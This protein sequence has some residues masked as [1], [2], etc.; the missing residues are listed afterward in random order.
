MG[1]AQL[2]GVSFFKTFSAEQRKRLYSFGLIQEI[3]RAAHAVIEGE[4]SRGLF[5]VFA[6]QL[7]VFKR[8]ELSSES[9]RLTHLKT[10]DCFGE[11]SL[12]DLAPR[13]ATVSADMISFIYFLDAG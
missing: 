9:M 6:G 4:P 11:L 10:R 13:S 5:I 8:D 12:I 3:K 7:S 1:A 2:D